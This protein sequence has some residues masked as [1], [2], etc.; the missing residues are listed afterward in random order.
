MDDMEREQGEAQEYTRIYIRGEGRGED[1]E[2]EERTVQVKR[3]TLFS[4][5]LLVTGCLFFTVTMP[6]FPYL[7]FCL[8][9]LLSFF[10]CYLVYW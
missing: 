4:D 7:T 9:L 2:G 6:T 8:S 1:E 10:S 3:L 5:C